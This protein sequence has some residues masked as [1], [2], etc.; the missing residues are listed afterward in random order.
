MILRVSPV[1]R[2]RKPKKNTKNKKRRAVGRSA[3]GGGHGGQPEPPGSALAWSPRPAAFDEPPAWFTEASLAVL[4]GA[5]VALAAR[6]PRELEQATVDLLGRQVRY[7]MREVRHGLRFESWF[8]EVAAVLAE[9]VQEDLVEGG[10]DAWEGSWWLLHGMT[11]IGSPAL[12]WAA[13]TALRDL[14]KLAGAGPGAA[15]PV[16]D[17]VLALRRQP[18]W[19]AQLPRI[20][21]TGEVWLLRDAYGCRFGVIAGMSYPDGV[22]PSVFLFDIDACGIVDLANAGAFDDVTRAAAAWRA[23][24]GDTAGGAHPTPVQTADQLECLVHWDSGELA[25]GWESDAALDNWFRARRRVHDVADALRGRGMPLPAHRSLYNRDATPLAEAF[26]AWYDARHGTKPDAAAVEALAEEW[27]DGCLPGTEHAASPHRVRFLLET[28]T[29]D[30]IE[31]DPI[32]V[33]VKPL[34]PDWVRWHGEQ[35]GLPDDLVQRAVDVAARHTE[36]ALS[37]HSMLHRGTQ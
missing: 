20:A 36:T 3:G 32:T 2:G 6:G 14:T 22:D 29:D 28:L 24:V 12:A 21:A 27:L 37:A 16:P 26:T 5:G 25:L 17:I 18:A 23:M 30:W 8:E 33:A 13:R 11:S 7:A 10:G 35:A 34:L 15:D 1:S 4:D 9:H 19:L 31:D